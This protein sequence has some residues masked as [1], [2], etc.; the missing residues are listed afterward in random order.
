MTKTTRF[1]AAYNAP[2][3]PLQPSALAFPLRP[4]DAAPMGRMRKIKPAPGMTGRI[5]YLTAGE[6]ATWPRGTVVTVLAEM[7]RK[8]YALRRLRPESAALESDRLTAIRDCEER[9]H[10]YGC[11]FT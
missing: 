5:H 10:R 11:E 8:L 3:I 2:E 9:L 7:V 6:I 1:Q 4:V